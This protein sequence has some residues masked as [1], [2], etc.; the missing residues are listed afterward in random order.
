MQAQ[1]ALTK[2]FYSRVLHYLLTNV[3]TLLDVHNNA[4]EVYPLVQQLQNNYEE[5]QLKQQLWQ[6]VYSVFGWDTAKYQLQQA[7]IQM[8]T[9]KQRL[10]HYQH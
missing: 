1:I 4:E 8:S 7:E 9:L 6:E 3:R 2:P 5:A 10:A